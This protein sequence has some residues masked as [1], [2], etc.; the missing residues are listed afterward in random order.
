METAGILN[1]ISRASMSDGENKR[2]RKSGYL[3]CSIYSKEI[4]SI[5]VAVKKDAFQKM[6]TKYGKSTVFKLELD[7]GK[8]Y[9]AMVKELQKA[10]MGGEYLHIS[11]HQV[12]LSEET[13]ADVSI[14]I[15]GKEVL[16]AKRLRFIQQMDSIPVKGLPNNIPNTID[17][18]VSEMQAG[19][20]LFIS[21]IKLPEGVFTE[22]SAEQLVV[23]V[24]MPRVQ[25]E[26]EVAAE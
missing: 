11:F 2:L 13:K 20:N 16:E 5:S 23:S 26:T 12:S 24:S 22:L 9:N 19:E 21:D 10:P 18:D 6:L 4:G 7:D 8:T 14:K 17:I 25:E 15:A 3:P 1:V